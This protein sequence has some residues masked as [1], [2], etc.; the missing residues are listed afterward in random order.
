MVR[1]RGRRIRLGCMDDVD[2]LIIKHLKGLRSEVAGVRTAMQDE[3]KDVKH[4]LGQI[5]TQVLG[6]R[7]DAMG[8][9]DEVYRQ[10]GVINAIKERLDCIERRLELQG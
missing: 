6:T 2:N 7:R 3:F 5:E 9:Q 10:Q 1:G 4:R 8:T